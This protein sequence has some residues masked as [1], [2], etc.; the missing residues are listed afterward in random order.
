L[1]R[2]LSWLSRVGTVL[3]APD[4]SLVAFGDETEPEEAH[5]GG[6]AERLAAAVVFVAE[7]GPSPGVIPDRR[8]VSGVASSGHGSPEREQ[9]DERAPEQS[10][11]D[12][13]GRLDPLS[14]SL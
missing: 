11:P 14:V 12:V 2:A 5:R 4:R 1:A 6:R 10:R 3:D 8:V 13:W 9:E 7:F